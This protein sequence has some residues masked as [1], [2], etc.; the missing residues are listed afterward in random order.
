MGKIAAYNF[1]SDH[2]AVFSCL[3]IRTRLSYLIDCLSDKWKTLASLSSLSTPQSNCLSSVK[4]AERTASHT[5]W[6]KVS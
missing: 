5:S 4:E 6:A 1:G 3:H 2:R